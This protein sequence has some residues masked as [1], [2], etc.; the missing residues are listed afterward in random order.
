MPQPTNINSYANEW[1]LLANQLEINPCVILPINNK[2]EAVR[3]RFR[4]YGF[5][6]T[7]AKHD[8]TN[9]W[10][11]ILLNVEV[12]IT[13]N[14]DLKFERNPFGARLRDLLERAIVKEG[15]I[16]TMSPPTPTSINNGNVIPNDETPSMPE[17]DQT[18]LNI[19]AHK[20]KP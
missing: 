19:L 5:R 15:P 13:D 20:D 18:I 8:A 9:P 11:A 12:T 16:T 14:G 2:K 4:F 1:M 6:R 7:L 17:H 3:A 10:A